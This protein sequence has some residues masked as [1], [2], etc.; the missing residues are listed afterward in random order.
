[1]GTFRAWSL[2]M[3]MM[4]MIE[5]ERTVKKKRS[6]RRRWWWWWGGGGG[7]EEENSIN[8]QVPLVIRAVNLQLHHT[9]IHITKVITAAS[10]TTLWQIAAGISLVYTQITAILWRVPFTMFW[11]RPLWTVYTCVPLL[12]NTQYSQMFNVYHCSFPH[13]LQAEIH[14]CLR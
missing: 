12:I 8:V 5:E 11:V 9:G 10:F 14:Q 13:F 2:M 7:D 3:M 6:W 4:I 1:M